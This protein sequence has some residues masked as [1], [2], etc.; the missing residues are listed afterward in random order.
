MHRRLS[1]ITILVMAVVICGSMGIWCLRGQ[2]ADQWRQNPSRL[3]WTEF[4]ELDSTAKPV[5][6]SG[7]SFCV[8]FEQVF[9]G[10]RDEPRAEHLDRTNAKWAVT[11]C[12]DDG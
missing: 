5:R 4:D 11:L 1:Y 3:L 2:I 7:H 8:V 12:D 9:Y 10:C 6:L